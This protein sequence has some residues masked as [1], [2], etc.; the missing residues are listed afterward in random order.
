[1]HEP[2][3][4]VN[5][6]KIPAR[7]PARIL[8]VDDEPDACEAL[9]QVLV[10]EGYDAIGETSAHR[11]LE[12]ARAEDFDLVLSDVSMREMNGV[13]LCRHLVQARPG[14]PVILVTG[15][16]TMDTAIGAMRSGARDFLTKPVQVDSLIVSIVQALQYRARSEG[17]VPPPRAS[18]SPADSSLA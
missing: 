4:R 16:G 3:L 10:S 17:S 8:V 1:M 14:V 2:A 11:A 18:L 5:Y 9:R 13:D 6:A 15:R 7:P 12:K